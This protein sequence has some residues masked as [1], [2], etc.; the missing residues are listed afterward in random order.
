[1]A[2]LR[3]G[4]CTSLLYLRGS[5]AVRDG[6]SDRASDLPIVAEQ[7]VCQKATKAVSFP[8][9]WPRKVKH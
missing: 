3:Y 2:W 1:V 4:C 6:P 5:M 9:F 8:Y 7:V